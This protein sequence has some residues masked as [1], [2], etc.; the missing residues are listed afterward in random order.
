MEQRTFEEVDTVG[1]K[2]SKLGLSHDNES[3]VLVL[4][5]AKRFHRTFA[6]YQIGLVSVEMEKLTGSAKSD[7]LSGLWNATFTSFTNLGS[8][9]Q[10]FGPIDAAIENEIA[11]E[12]AAEKLAA[13]EVVQETKLDGIDAEFNKF[14]NGT[15]KPPADEDEDAE[16]A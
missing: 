4:E 5:E 13:G 16:A 11:T 10:K 2:A 3:A 1:R 7:M 6:N 8:A 9:L 15:P 12:I 14:M